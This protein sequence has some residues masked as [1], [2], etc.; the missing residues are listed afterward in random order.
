MYDLLLLRRSRVIFT[1]SDECRRWM[2]RM[3]G[4]SMVTYTNVYFDPSLLCVSFF[5]LLLFYIDWSEDLM[6][7]QFGQ[8]MWTCMSTISF[9]LR[10]RCRSSEVTFNTNQLGK[11]ERER[12]GERKKEN[13]Y[14]RSRDS[15]ERIYIAMI[16]ISWVK[17]LKTPP[18]TK[19]GSGKPKTLGTSRGTVLI[20][21]FLSSAKVV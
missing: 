15:W 4:T 13:D 6:S 3:K 5:L 19:G 18:M 12:E 2:S 21:D 8:Q 16:E 14:N 7:K 10:N 20:K 17:N 1:W 9:R 11:K